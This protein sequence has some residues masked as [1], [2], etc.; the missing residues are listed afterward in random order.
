MYEC[1]LSLQSLGHGMHMILPVLR[2]CGG[3]NY[4]AGGDIYEDEGCFVEMRSIALAL[5]PLHAS[6]V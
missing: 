2:V 5:S 3:Q 4:G 1:M 6:G